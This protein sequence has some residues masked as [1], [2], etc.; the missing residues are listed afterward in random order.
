MD[1]EWLTGGI[2][3]LLAIIYHLGCAGC[4]EDGIVNEARSNGA[5]N[6]NSANTQSVTTRG[7]MYM[8]PAHRA[9]YLLNCSIEELSTSVFGRPPT[10][11][12]DLSALDCLRGFVQGLYQTVVDT[13]LMLINR[14]F[15][16]RFL[17]SIPNS[18]DQNLECLFRNFCSYVFGDPE[19]L[20]RVSDQ[21]RDYAPWLS[22]TIAHMQ[23]S[24]GINKPFVF[25]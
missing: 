19:I 12:N 14:Y 15:F 17:L 25:D 20:M 21:W 13:L 6:E 4:V 8:E 2:A 7:F 22:G 11:E 9:A 23:R 16:Y 18:D 10:D 3:R 1:N 5:E 24:A